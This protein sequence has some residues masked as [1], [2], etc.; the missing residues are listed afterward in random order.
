MVSTCLAK[1]PDQRWQSAGDPARELK[2]IS[3][4]EHAAGQPSTARSDRSLRVAMGLVGVAS[5]LVGAALVFAAFMM[6]RE[7]SVACPAIAA[8]VVRPQRHA[9]GDAW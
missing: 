5:A 9:G 4:G 7:A 8:Q 3:S 2:W 6:Q 1:D